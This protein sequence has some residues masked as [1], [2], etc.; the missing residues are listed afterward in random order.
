[1]SAYKSSYLTATG[2]GDKTYAEPVRFDCY[3][4]DTTEKITDKHGNE[5]V[6]RTKIFAVPETILTPE[7]MI[8]FPDE[9]EK[10]EIHKLSTYFDGNTGLRDIWVIY[11]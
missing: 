5:Y 9:T 4:L 1:M 3:R 10:Y 2:T 11:L 6:A 7:D 8:S